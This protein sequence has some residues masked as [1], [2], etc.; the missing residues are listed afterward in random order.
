[1]CVHSVLIRK[2]ALDETGYFDESVPSYED[3]DLW[4][5]LS[6]HFPF[7][8]VP[9]LVGVYLVSPRGLWLSDTRAKERKEQVLAKAM[10]MLPDTLRSAE[11]KRTAR[12]RLAL[13]TSETW[14]EIL[15]TLR[16]YPFM[17]RYGW[18]R[19]WVSS[20]MRKAALKSDSPLSALQELCSQVKKVASCGG[21]RNRWQIRHT[22]AKAWAETASYLAVRRKQNREAG[23]A[24]GQ[25]AALA[26]FLLLRGTLGIIIVRSALAF[27][28]ESAGSRK[29][30]GSLGCVALDF[31]PCR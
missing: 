22:L 3:W 23:Y 24:A 4:L 2:E 25:A 15:A 28:I 26:P 21:A 18:A 5:R 1:M 29:R 10:Q 13:E 14:A 8:F 16:E 31:T 7:V 20:S 27:C 17:V 12:A 11:L 30:H 9:G 19:Q 6:F